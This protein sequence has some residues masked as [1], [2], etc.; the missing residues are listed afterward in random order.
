MKGGYK[1]YPNK[2]VKFDPRAITSRRMPE[3]LKVYSGQL[4]YGFN[5]LMI[6][7]YLTKSDR[8][9]IVEKIEMLE[10]YDQTGDKLKSSYWCCNKSYLIEFFRT[11]RTNF[12]IYALQLFFFEESQ[13]IDFL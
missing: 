7:G 1:E 5:F 4:N 12:K 10:S 2:G 6:N 13:T 8:E 9:K 3:S 11:S